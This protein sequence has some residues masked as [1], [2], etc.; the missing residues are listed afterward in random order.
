L[1]ADFVG[2]AN[3]SNLYFPPLSENIYQTKFSGFSLLA[4]NLKFR[5]DIL[6]Q[7]LTE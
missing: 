7:L 6:Q 2:M 3:S 5:Q 1:L 4:N